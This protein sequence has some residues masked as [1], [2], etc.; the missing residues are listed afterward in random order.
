MLSNFI[1]DMDNLVEKVNIY[2]RNKLY[3]AFGN[4]SYD[5]CLQS[6]PCLTIVGDLPTYKG[7]KKTIVGEYEKC[8]R[9]Y[10]IVFLYKC[11]Y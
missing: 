5:K 8:S 3:D 2:E 9:S 6:I 1:A 4:L 11:K 10:K 7:D